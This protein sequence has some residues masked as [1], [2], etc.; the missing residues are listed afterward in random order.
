[1]KVSAS[2]PHDSLRTSF[3]ISFFFAFTLSV[4]TQDKPAFPANPAPVAPASSN[5]AIP[6]TLAASTFDV[7]SIKP[8]QRDPGPSY[9]F[10]WRTAPEGFSAKGITTSMLIV[11][12]YG[13]HSPDEVVNLPGWAGSDGFDIRAKT[14]EET[15]AA[16]RKLPDAE[17]DR[18]LQPMLQSLLAG[19]FQL[20]IH[21]EIRQLPVYNLIVAKGGSKMKASTTTGIGGSGMS[22]GYISGEGVPISTLA[23]NLSN[24]IGRQVID[25][26]G[27]SGNYDFKLTWT[28]DEMRAAPDASAPSDSGP[29]VFA[30]IQE[31][32]GLKLES[33]KGPVDV[34]VVDHVE[35]P[36]EN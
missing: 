20:K 9:G 10:G 35:K 8:H 21:H 12:A 30:A 2:T 19:R 28:A 18:K 25:K 26:T 5:L 23:F 36:S 14:D 22:N 32:L 6:A 24:E 34:L 15:A 27:L 3:L 11:L 16:L 13:L 7:V 29:S 33:A 31:Q 17:I 1:M 4:F